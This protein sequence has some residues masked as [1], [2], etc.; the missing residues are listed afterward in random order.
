M[1][2]LQKLQLQ[3]ALVAKF[4]ATRLLWPRPA[5]ALTLHLV[6]HMQRYKPYPAPRFRT[7]LSGKVGRGK[8]KRAER[9]PL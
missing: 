2:L 1:Y 8:K 3:T 7:A 5:G 9:E 4:L 6:Q